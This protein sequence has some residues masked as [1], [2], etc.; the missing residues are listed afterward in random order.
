MKGVLPMNYSL[1]N[2]S[3]IVTTFTVLDD[4]NALLQLNKHI[5]GRKSCLNLAE[6]ATISLIRSEFC[7][8]NWKG[9]YKLLVKRF[10]HDF[11]LPCYKNFV[12]TMNQSAKSLLI[13]MNILLSMN[14][15]KAGTIKLVDSTTIPVCK[16]YNIHRHKTMKHI[17]TRS[18]SSLGW[19]YGLKLHAM[20]DVFGNLLE[21]RFTTANVG[22]RKILDVFLEKLHNSIVIVDAGYISPKLE[23]KARKNNNI[24]L[25]CMRKNM[26]KLST[27]LDICLLNLRPRIEVLFSL[28]KERL[29][30]ITS[31]PRSVNGYLAH[32]IH[33]IFGYLVLKAIS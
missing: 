5:S 33:V 14:R 17:A 4:L 25:T 11:H 20:T 27:F 18:K 16:N 19:F 10:S 15:K 1:S 8:R 24:L 21:L 3:S 32:Y 28:L 23:K 12:I 9:L 22:D 31:L 30:L 7:I 2:P 6:A 26:K 29:G 13:L